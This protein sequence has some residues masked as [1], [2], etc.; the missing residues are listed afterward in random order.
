MNLK[1]FS[2]LSFIALILLLSIPFRYHNKSDDFKSDPVNYLKLSTN[3]SN[4]DFSKLPEIN[5]DIWYEPK[6][7]MLV[8]T[9][10]NSDFIDAITP[11]VEW[12]N[13]KGLKT[14]ILSNF[15]E[16][17]GRDDAERIRN[18]IKSYYER[19]NIKWVLL[20]GDAQENLIPIRYVYNPD[21]I[22]VGPP[23]REH[24]NNDWDNHYKPTDFYY[25]D[26]NGSWDE[27]NDNIFGESAEYNKNG[28]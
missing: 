1:K 21:V 8:I 13:N 20:I 5:Y 23:E 28:K 3:S 17:S 7:E 25:A 26:L 27:D 9:P 6:V 12:K 18:M 10:N 14:I 15:S 16:Y 19:E 2:V 4:I 24:W 22:V 11:L